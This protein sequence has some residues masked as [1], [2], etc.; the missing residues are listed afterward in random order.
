[1]IIL[2]ASG[3]ME[4]EV[5]PDYALR[6][7]RDGQTELVRLLWD[8]MP[9][10]GRIVFVTSHIAHFRLPPPPG[11]GGVAESKRAGE[12]A[13][14]AMAPALAERRLDLVVVSGTMVPGTVTSVLLSRRAHAEPPPPHTETLP[15]VMEFAAALVHAAVATETPS[16]TIYVGDLPSP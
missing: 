12:S 5:P 8:A 7:N 11:Y 15:T 2:N 6:L 3:G 13:L 1:M 16:T 9:P 14:R 4:Y 10:G